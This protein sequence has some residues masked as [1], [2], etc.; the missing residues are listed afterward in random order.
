MLYNNIVITSDKA[1]YFKNDEKVYTTGNSKAV[2]D[3][4]TITASNLEYDKI[5]N[6]FKAKKNA[7][8]KAILKKKQLF[9]QMKLLIL[10]TMK[11]FTQQEILKLLMTTIQLQPQI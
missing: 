7:V 4:N 8:A 3:N 6:I 10:R 1:I 5:N 2:N 9:M 11:R